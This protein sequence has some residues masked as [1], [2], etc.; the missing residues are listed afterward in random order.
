[1]WRY[2]RVSLD[3]GDNRLREMARKRGLHGCT[4][5]T[6]HLPEHVHEYMK[7]AISRTCMTCSTE[8]KVSEEL[9]FSG[10]AGYNPVSR[11][12]LLWAHGNLSSMTV[13]GHPETS[14]VRDRSRKQR[15]T[16]II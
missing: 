10:W 3:Q 5:L 11:G 4:A 12:M 9:R 2:A 16:T 8:H 14:L 1:M 7:Q 6:H 13:R 15:K